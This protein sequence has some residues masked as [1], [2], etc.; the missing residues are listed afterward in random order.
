V[1][2]SVQ[3]ATTSQAPAF[4]HS[5]ARSRLEKKTSTAVTTLNSRKPSGSGIAVPHEAATCGPQVVLSQQPVPATC[6]QGNVFAMQ[7][8]YQ[9]GHLT[10]MLTTA[11]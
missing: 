6:A 7:M 11:L 3:C 5:R 8:A 1:D 2:R 4:Q 9:L 10:G